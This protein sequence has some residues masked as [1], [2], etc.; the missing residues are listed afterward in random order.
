MACTFA[1]YWPELKVVVTSP[2]I[3]FADYPTNAFPKNQVIDVAVGDLVRIRE[4]S[5]TFHDAAGHPAR[6]LGGRSRTHPSAA[7]TI[8]PVMSG[9]VKRRTNTGYIRAFQKPSARTVYQ[10]PNLQD[11]PASSIAFQKVMVSSQSPPQTCSEFAENAD[12]IG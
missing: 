6:R 10:M 9:S 8:E 5:G 2:Q 12:R 7:K 11:L 3:P 1:W 4:Y